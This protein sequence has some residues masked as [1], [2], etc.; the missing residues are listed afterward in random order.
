MS[1]QFTVNW[2]E[3]LFNSAASKIKENDA[4][5]PKQL[6]QQQQVEKKEEKETSDSNP[7]NKK[8]FYYSRFT[9][10]EI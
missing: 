4:D 2:W 10:V 9:K 1:D 5:A 6:Q 7:L 8:S 3:H